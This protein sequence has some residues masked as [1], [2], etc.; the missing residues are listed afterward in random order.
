[1]FHRCRGLASFVRGS[2]VWLHTELTVYDSNN[3]GTTIL[4]IAY[5]RTQ[6]DTPDGGYTNV[7]KIGM[8]FKTLAFFLGLGYVFIDHKYLGKAMT[9]GEMERV[10]QEQEIEDERSKLLHGRS[11]RSSLTS[12]D[13]FQ[14]PH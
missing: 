5:G 13:V 10:R 3:S 11:T 9:M 1:M 2:C 14:L 12:F 4:N 7:L 6:D 8:A